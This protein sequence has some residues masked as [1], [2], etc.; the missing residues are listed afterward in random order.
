MIHN[1]KNSWGKL[2]G[3]C[4]V[5]ACITSACVIAAPKKKAPVRKAKPK[6]PATSVM[7]VPSGLKPDSPNRYRVYKG[8]RCV[9]FA[10]VG[11][12]QGLAPGKYD[13]RVGFQSGWVSRP[14][15]LKSGQKAI[16]PTGL[17]AFRK[18]AP[19]ANGSTVP[20]K[21]YQG[22]TYLASGY[23]GQTARLYPGKYNVRYH[24]PGDV[25]PAR[26]LRKWHVMGSF[27]IDWRKDLKLE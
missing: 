8:S 14:I 26:T 20:Q 22:D 9:S 18:I 10:R 5:F 3:I 6:P 15:E 13:V 17:F 2:V 16:V 7:I 12:P 24:L 23:Y 25:N 11:R 1:R 19:A 27:P 4:V 21:L